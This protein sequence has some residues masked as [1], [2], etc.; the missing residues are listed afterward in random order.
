VVLTG[1]VVIIAPSYAPV[2]SNNTNVT[3]G[4]SGTVVLI[5]KA[6][7]TSQGTNQVCFVNST[8]IST[9]NGVFLPT[10]DTTAAVVF[11][12]NIVVPPSSPVASGEVT[13]TYTGLVPGSHPTVTLFIR[14]SGYGSLSYRPCQTTSETLTA[15]TY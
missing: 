11:V 15:L 3:V 4:P 6:S 8:L 7:F 1:G 10:D 12:P 9:L 14:D 2:I 13:N 5:A